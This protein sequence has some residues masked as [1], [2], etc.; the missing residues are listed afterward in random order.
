MVAISAPLFQH[1]DRKMKAN[2]TH[3]LGRLLASKDLPP[4]Y[5][6]AAG[7]VILSGRGSTSLVMRALSTTYSEAMRVV[8]RLEADGILSRPD[9]N[10]KRTVLVTRDTVALAFRSSASVSLPMPEL[11]ASCGSCLEHRHDEPVTRLED[12]RWDGNQWCCEECWEP[13]NA[14]AW[15]D[16]PV[17]TLALDNAPIRHPA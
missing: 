9:H 17:A 12:L 11:F 1:M 7:V 15:H 8:E 6:A 4:D 16:A 13:G 5:L 10:G 2:Q 14:T 3:P